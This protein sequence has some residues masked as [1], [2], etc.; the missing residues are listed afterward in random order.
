M[1]IIKL[2]QRAVLSKRVD[3]PWEYEESVIYEPIYVV[4]EHIESFSWAG[5]TYLKMISGERIEVR[6]T[7]EEVIDQIQGGEPADSLGVWA[8][9]GESE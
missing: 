8:G 9:L 4:A 3:Q 5:N 2:S 7:A 6:E 1:Q